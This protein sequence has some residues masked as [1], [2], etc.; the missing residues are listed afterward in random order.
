MEE[1]EYTVAFELISHA[2]DSKSESMMAI[3]CAREFQ[4]EEAKEHLMKAGEKLTKAHNSH[5]NLIQ[6]EAKGEKVKVNIILVHAQDHL[7]GAIL[8][9]DQAE[10]FINLY[11]MIKEIK[12]QYVTKKNTNIV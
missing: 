5:L 9:K 1:M 11:Q 12:E 2:G 7:S 10:E 8:I 6:N 3:E 4:F